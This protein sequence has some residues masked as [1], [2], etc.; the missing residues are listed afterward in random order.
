MISP[1]YF[2][3]PRHKKQ[4][5]TEDTETRTTGDETLP[6]PSTFYS[7]SKQPCK[8]FVFTFFVTPV[9]I[10]SPSPYINKALLVNF[11]SKISIFF[12]CCPWSKVCMIVAFPPHP[13]AYL[14][15][16]GYLLRTPG[17]SNPFSISLEGSSY[18][19][20]TVLSTLN[21][22]CTHQKMIIRM[23]FPISTQLLPSFANINP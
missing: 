9:Q 17:N 13:F 2:G 18:R 15:I 12:S 20:S 1:Q 5:G 10:Q 4:L 7:I 23:A 11:F 19:E 22:F 3:F 6:S 8:F 16:F 14:L 21:I